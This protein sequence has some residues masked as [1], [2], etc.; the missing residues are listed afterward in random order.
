MKNINIITVLVF[1]FAIG[2]ACTPNSKEVTV[3]KK[4]EVGVQSEEDATKKSSYIKARAE[5]EEQRQL[6]LLDKIKINPTFTDGAGNIVYYKAEV[7]PSYTGG[8]DKLNEYL[9]KNLKY[10]ADA[11]E[12]GYEGT[13]FV[14]FVIDANGNV[15]E[16]VASDVVGEYIN[17]SFKEESVRVVAAMPGWKPGVQNGKAVATSFSIPIIFQLRN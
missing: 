2:Q 3:D 14:D 9:E 17:E 8:M 12:K 13:V 15:R 4:T 6:A 10:P 11:Q 1:S 16:V 5:K 7:D